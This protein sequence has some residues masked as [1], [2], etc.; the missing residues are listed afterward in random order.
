MGR[1]TVGRKTVGLKTMGRKIMG[2]KTVGLKTVGL[3]MMRSR[4]NN[5]TFG[6]ER[7][8]GEGTRFSGGY[9]GHLV[10]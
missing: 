9:Y 8:V 4:Q 10:I 3:K 5:V 2:Q 1:K 7:T 6:I